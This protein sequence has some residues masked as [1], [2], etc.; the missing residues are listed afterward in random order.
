MVGKKLYPT[1]K[2]EHTNMWYL[3][4]FIA[5]KLYDSSW[6]VYLTLTYLTISNSHNQNYETDLR[7]TCSITT[8]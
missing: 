8:V 7:A 6:S 2:I 3:R 4:L 1:A 5:K